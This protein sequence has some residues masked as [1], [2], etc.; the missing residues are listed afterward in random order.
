MTVSNN[1]RRA[2]EKKGMS[3]A[4]LALALGV[5]EN[6]VW[7]WENDKSTPNA[8]T[9]VNIADVLDSTPAELL[10]AKN[11]EQAQQTM[12]SIAVT[13]EKFP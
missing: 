11:P 1:I 8:S 3:Q 12:Q 5:K 13:H 9:I 4:K 10:P 2:R 6:T 7:R